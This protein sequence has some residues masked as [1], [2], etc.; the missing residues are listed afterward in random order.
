MILY[1]NSFVVLD[2]EPTTDILA[3]EW[4]NVEAYLLPEAKRTLKTLVEYVRNYDVKRLLIDESKTTVSPELIDSPEYKEVLMEFVCD[5]TKTRLQKSARIVALDKD[6]EAK[7]KK[8][9]TE[10][11]QEIKLNISNK[12]FT[13]KSEAQSWLLAS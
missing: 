10:I 8:L 11:I 3:F 9:T 7:T 6:R 5:L 12:D 1:Q 4:P 13:N 2:Y